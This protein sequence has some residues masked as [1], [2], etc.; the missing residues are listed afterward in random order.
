MTR[1]FNVTGFVSN[2]VLSAQK[3]I[4]LFAPSIA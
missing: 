2:D 4:C 1:F 3:E